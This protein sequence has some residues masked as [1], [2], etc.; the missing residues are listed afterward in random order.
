KDLVE[1][2]LRDGATTIVAVGNDTI[3]SRVAGVLAG[4]KDITL[5]FIPLGNG[6]HELAR[7][8][9]IPTGLLACQVLSS[10]MIESISLGKIGN[11]HFLQSAY[12]RGQPLLN[13]DNQYRLH[14]NSRHLVKICNLDWYDTPGSEVSN[15]QNDTLETIVR[16]LVKQHWWHK[17]SAP[18][19][20][21]ASL[22]PVKTL[23]LSSADDELSLV[24]DGYQIIKTPATITILPRKLR[25][26]VGKQRLF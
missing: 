10:R 18:R 3:L 13:F 17:F 22:L 9:G 6:P 23:Q 12:L 8:L 24:L 7:I 2:A 14:L 1:T 11:Y 20:A 25:L 26:I 5:G 4:K 15:P 21:A 19:A 16:P